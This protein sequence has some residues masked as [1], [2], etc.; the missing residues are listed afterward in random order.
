MNDILL[1]TGLLILSLSILVFW[2]ELGHYL[3]AKWFGMKVEK[4][5][6]FF[7]W[8]RKLFSKNVGET[9]YG[10]GL[11]PLGG[12]VKIAGMIDES[13]DKN[14]LAEPAQSWE[15]RSK[16]AWQRLIV[17][18]GG[19]VMNIILGIFIFTVVKYTR[20]EE[21]LPMSS[22]PA[23][24]FVPD[25]SVSQELGFK[26]GDK[27]MSF[28][29]Q[30]IKY[31]EDIAHPGIL[32]N[33]SVWFEVDR[34]GTPIRIDIP[35]DLIDQFANKGKAAG[36]LFYPN[37]ENWVV[38]DSTMPA[39]KAG[40][41]NGDQVIE[42]EGKTINYFEEL[43]A[44]IKNRTD[45]SIALVWLRN[46]DTMRATIVLGSEGLLGL[47]PEDRFKRDKIEY[48]FFAAFV[49]GTKA[50]FGVIFD[51]FKGVRKI[52][53][54][55]VSASNSVAGP[56]RIA[57]M[58]GVNFQRDGWLGF[59]MLTGMLSMA[60]AFMNILPIPAL[61][62]GHVVFLLIEMIIRR[63]PSLKVR[64]IA[65]QVGMVILLALMAFVIFND[66]IATVFK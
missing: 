30:P 6:L 17:M 27:I 26:T 12:Y 37:A 24:I 33:D 55:E 18:V 28:S 25:S 43:R 66:I 59:W 15:F 21:R 5:Y 34:Q 62:G 39:A 23:G 11:L 20:G 63:E 60:L 42:I 58:I 44:T 8:P 16:P 64:M 7:D 47:A 61:D 46:Q 57:G 3:P 22:L 13:L 29:G 9:E 14:Q 52:F 32:L 50:A 49:P 4:F 56:V 41:Q 45:D 19:V 35:G 54:G 31:F 10:V 2:H 65:Q 36:M 40:V 48:G 51:T 53:K 38:V 1:Y